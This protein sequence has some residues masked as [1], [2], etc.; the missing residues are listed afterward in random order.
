MKPDQ[1]MRKM[2]RRRKDNARKYNKINK[3]CMQH[4]LWNK[5]IS[6]IKNTFI[7][8]NKSNSQNTTPKDLITYAA[9]DAGI[10]IITSKETSKD[11]I[12]T[13]HYKINLKFGEDPKFNSLMFVQY[14][15]MLEKIIINCTSIKNLDTYFSITRKHDMNKQYNAEITYYD[16]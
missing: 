16:H 13:E 6:N 4:P 8:L 10:K 5:F 12:Y 2:I 9:Q 3:Q 11:N 1:Q 14:L 15:L 7:K